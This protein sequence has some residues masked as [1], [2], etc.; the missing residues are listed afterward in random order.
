[1]LGSKIPQFVDEAFKKANAA[2]KSMLLEE[3]LLVMVVDLLKK[4]CDF[5][6]KYQRKI[7]KNT[8]KQ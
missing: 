4:D 2:D 5:W 1:V 8:G 7:L 6:W 3:G